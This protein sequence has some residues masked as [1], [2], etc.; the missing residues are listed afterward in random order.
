MMKKIAEFFSKW[1]FVIILN[2]IGVALLFAL[3]CCIYTA[4]INPI[5]G[6]VGI[7]G[8]ATAITAVVA[9]MCG[10]IKDVKEEEKWRTWQQ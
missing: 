5:V 8:V 2:L 4:I 3:G 10:E 9:L 7:V 6:G 1:G